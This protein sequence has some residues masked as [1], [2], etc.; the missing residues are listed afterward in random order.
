MFGKPKKV[1]FSKNEQKILDA[2]TKVLDDPEISER[3]KEIFTKAK[4]L[5]MSGEYVP[6][7]VKRLENTLRPMAV[8]RELSPEVGK[9]FAGISRMLTSVLPFGSNPNSLV[10]NGPTL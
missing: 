10:V 2:I 8:S 3:E 1:K 7:V 4:N 9:F 5:M 6:N